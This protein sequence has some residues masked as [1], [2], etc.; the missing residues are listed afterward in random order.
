M[1]TSFLYRMVGSVLRKL[2]I[3]QVHRDSKHS[4]QTYSNIITQLKTIFARFGIPATM[5]GN[6]PNLTLKK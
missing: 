6:G 3:I 1:F 5:V 4:N 2:L